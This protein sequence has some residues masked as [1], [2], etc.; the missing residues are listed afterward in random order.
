M[1][2]EVEAGTSSPLAHLSD[3]VH[4]PP[5]D[6]PDVVP[7][8]I[9]WNE[10]GFSERMLDEHLSQS[11]DGASRRLEL[12]DRQVD[13][14]H[15]TLLKGSP[16]DVLDLGCGPGLYSHRL[17]ARRHR[18][19]GID[20]SPASIAYARA[21]AEAEELDCTFRLQDLTTGEFGGPHDLAMLIFGELNTFDPAAAASLLQRVRAAL[22][23]GGTLL[24]EPHPLDVV[25]RVGEAP[26]SW[27]SSEGGLFSPRPHL[28]L[29]EHRWFSEEAVAA[30][31]YLVVDAATGEVDV[32]GQ[33]LH[34]FT[35]EQYR[36]VIVDAGFDDVE[37]HP[38]M[39]VEVGDDLFVI[40]AIAS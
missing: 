20:F 39:G 3:I 21:G 36:T 1:N 38:S 16:S 31:R 18:C 29:A 24:L 30:A 7:P 22:R 4:R 5:L 12:I 32:F 35:D 28:T 40:T 8:K 6:R 37:F 10:P 14:I 11:H 25:R 2:H 19:L 17:A 23:P 15:T 27:Y 9:P 13:W 33:R 26:S 34:A